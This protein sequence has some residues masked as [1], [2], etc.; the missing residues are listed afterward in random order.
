MADLPSLNIQQQN[1]DL[2]L[3]SRLGA[4]QTGQPA[5]TVYNL[6]PYTPPDTK[7]LYSYQ[8]SPWADLAGSIY[9]TAIMDTGQGLSNLIPTLANTVGG[10]KGFDWAN[11]W[12]SSVDSWMDNNK[13]KISDAGQKS[14][15][16][17]PSLNSFASTL[18][19]VLGFVGL[20][21]GT[22][23][24]GGAAGATSLV[25]RT[26]PSA[27]AV[28]LNMMPQMSKM[29]QDAGIPAD[30]A[31]RMSLLLS[32]VMGASSVVGFNA[33]MGTAGKTV[34]PKLIED[35]GLDAAEDAIKQV[36]SAPKITKEVMYDAVKIANRTFTDKLK[37]ALPKILEG[38]AIG[39]ADMGAQTY[40]TE[41]LKNLYDTTIA[42]SGAKT[43]KGMFGADVTSYDTF[44][45]AFENA[46]LGGIIG[47][48]MSSVHNF[49]QPL[50]RE[51][52]FSYIGNA[53]SDGKPE[54]ITQ[55]EDMAQKKIQAG[56][57]TPEDGAQFATT[58]KNLVD[59]NKII[60]TSIK[61]NTTRY[62]AFNIISDR[63]EIKDTLAKL[64]QDA[65]T[66]DPSLAQSDAAEMSIHQAKID[67]Y[68]DYLQKIGRDKSPIDEKE[69]YSK[70]SKLDGIQEDL[71]DKFEKNATEETPHEDVDTEEEPEPTIESFMPELGGEEAT[72]ETQA[73][74][75]VEANEQGEEPNLK[76]L[77]GQMEDIKSTILKFPVDGDPK[78]VRALKKQSS[79]I[80][81]K[82]KILEDEQKL[83]DKENAKT[84]PNNENTEVEP[85][86][87][88]TAE[89]KPTA[90]PKTEVPAVDEKQK[91]VTTKTQ[92]NEETKSVRE[93]GQSQGQEGGD[94]GEQP[95]RQENGRQGKE[96]ATVAETKG[97]VEETQLRKDTLGRMFPQDDGKAF[98]TS[99]GYD[100]PMHLMN[101]VNKELGKKLTTPD[102]VT[103]EDAKTVAKK[104]V[105]DAK[106]AAK[107]VKKVK[108][109]KQDAHAVQ[110]P[111]TEVVHGSEQVETKQEGSKLSGVGEGEQGSKTPK[112]SKPA[113]TKEVSKPDKTVEKQ[114]DNK[115][116]EKK[117]TTKKKVVEEEPEPKNKV[118]EEYEDEGKRKK[119]EEEPDIEELAKQQEKRGGNQKA[120]TTDIKKANIIRGKI[121]DHTTSNEA[122]KLVND[123][124]DRYE[125]EGAESLKASNV[126]NLEQNHADGLDGMGLLKLKAFVEDNII[127]VKKAKSQAGGEMMTASKSIGNTNGLIRD[128]YKNTTKR[129]GALQKDIAIKQLIHGLTNGFTITTDGGI[130][131][132]P[133]PYEAMEKGG[134]I[135]LYK[136]YFDAAIKK[137]TG[138]GIKMGDSK[139][140]M[141]NAIANDAFT[142]KAKGYGERKGI[143]TESQLDEAIKELKTK[144]QLKKNQRG[145]TPFDLISKDPK[146]YQALKN[147]LAK[148]Y[149]DFIVREPQEIADK[150]GVINGI[151][152]VE[153]LKRVV[154]WS[155][156]DGRLD[157]MPHEYM[158]HYIQDMVNDPL[159]QEGIKKY[160]SEEA[161]VQAMGE[162][163]TKDFMKHIDDGQKTW[164]GK[165]I[166]KVIEKLRSMFATT[167]VADKI[168]QGFRKGEPL[169]EPKSDGVIGYQKP[170]QSEID[171]VQ[172]DRRNWVNLTA[173]EDKALDAFTTRTL[174]GNTSKTMNI[175]KNIEKASVLSD[176][177]IQDKLTT[178][179]GTKEMVK[180]VGKFVMET[181]NDYDANA[182]IGGT[183]LNLIT[184][185]KINKL[186]DL[187]SVGGNPEQQVNFVEQLYKSF[188]YIAAHGEIPSD[189]PKN[190]L[191]N[192]LT[193][194]SAIEHNRTMKLNAVKY[195]VGSGQAV[196]DKTGKPIFNAKGKPVMEATRID[197]DKANAVGHGEINNVFTKIAKAGLVA[198]GSMKAI[199]ANP[200]AVG[201][202]TVIESISGGKDSF[203]TKL[204][205]EPQ[206]KGAR[207][208][209][210][211]KRDM[212]D[213][214]HEGMTEANAKGTTFM[215]NRTRKNTEKLSFTTRNGV[216]DITKGE[217]FSTYMHAED[218]RYTEGIIDQID[219]DGKIKEGS[220]FSLSVDGKE[221]KIHFTQDDYDKFKASFEKDKELMKA[222]SSARKITDFMHE[223]INE[224]QQILTGMPTQKLPNYWPTSV[225][226]P[227]MGSSPMVN[228]MEAY[229]G[230]KGRTGT[231]EPIRLGDG[232]EEL[233]R[234]MNDANTY[235]SKAIP[236][237]T[238]KSWIGNKENQNVLMGHG[239]EKIVRY[240]NN[241]ITNE[242][243]SRLLYGLNNANGERSWMQKSLNNLMIS[244]VGFNPWVLVKQL[245]AVTL[246]SSEFGGKQRYMGKAYA[247]VAKI[248]ANGTVRGFKINENHPLFQEIKQHAPYLINRI[249]TT[250]TGDLLQS[251]GADVM[252]FNHLKTGDFTATMKA[253]QRKST[254]MIKLADYGRIA[255]IW[256]ASKLWVNDNI[257]SLQESSKAWHK[258]V[259][260][261]A[262]QVEIN[263]QPTYDSVHRTGLQK[264]Q[265][266]LI[267]A[268]TLFG[269]QPAKNLDMLISSYINNFH[270]PSAENKAIM[271]RNYINVIA[272]NSIL[273]SAID[274]SKQAGKHTTKDNEEEMFWGL[275]KTNL[276]NLPG[277]NMLSE[278]MIS[279]LRRDK[280]H[281]FVK[282]VSAPW[283]DMANDGLNAM[284]LLAKGKFDKGIDK[285]IR[286]GM[287]LSGVPN[288]PYRFAQSMFTKSK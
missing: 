19:N 62:Q 4:Q 258:A 190:V 86:S 24:L 217:A 221:T 185:E 151:A 7:D 271:R 115:A 200:N 216:H 268:F 196:N 192:F 54:R 158:H 98:A 79:I 70:I 44:K 35:L 45:Q 188:N 10:D 177:D 183:D 238:L 100:H 51:S 157:T 233:N 252:N 210:D 22:S 285:T 245:P 146:T 219:K 111:S 205:Y 18:G 211:N 68:N 199:L 266:P 46:A 29:A 137:E 84:K 250:S 11:N 120:E 247:T 138:L 39:A 80:K 41:G 135:K 255:G 162:S 147:A 142:P 173:A 78:V 174:R 103:I 95:E 209:E 25:A 265:N 15:F 20:M 197:A 176:T 207:D 94:K 282:N 234:F 180:H 182:K 261:K 145:E 83:K 193:L 139:S 113:E 17:D 109:T 212:A 133:S 37:T 161:L 179:E 170:S 213:L 6:Q 130:H 106:A 36:A 69:L 288:Y 229:K 57:M 155:I 123:I 181:L 246:T 48:G 168:L 105:A 91:Q 126:R 33:I 220:G 159:V 172:N 104:K 21:A 178:S 90:E 73:V 149:P 87:E 110:K 276:N 107:E 254:S 224:T 9:N 167:D 274:M 3:A 85:K 56:K 93:D 154:E 136:D 150:D 189:I 237:H 16:T 92:D 208:F 23:G 140:D 42:P 225:G 72:P 43:G 60:P 116:V 169:P 156:T 223:K 264:N 281:P 88:P 8:Q 253:L 206:N 2:N 231:N 67:I 260:N 226:S 52:L 12:T 198:R 127:H 143:M 50:M 118:D 248:I 236:L 132:I 14:F 280:E 119:P 272:V 202:K 215:G 243:N 101:D 82:I 122:A 124:F 31:A 204:L 81:E 263:T 165:F 257:P 114:R 5:A 273:M 77:Q 75:Q 259:S 184:K 286:V 235:A 96:T 144:P 128:L 227:T 244:A 40:M 191:S 228:F 222:V 278:A 65:S 164:I 55:V 256:E 203:L 269:S 38:S 27:I 129:L 148:L 201:L 284:A 166:G 53:M 99:L 240:V 102:D 141:I 214:F 26:A 232:F 1:L 239:Q 34:A 134:I 242:E 279:R 283:E 71:D 187:M 160:G 275:V 121:L 49:N 66:A 89:T 58:M 76:A 152:H 267:R 74:K 108:Q 175:E 125:K 28:T 131:E 171:R 64:Q 218:P 230:I 163:Y 32:G 251:T 112:E 13:S 270:N 241:Y 153:A 47:A 97:K 30:H 59:A 277:V 63:N 287:T 186:R 61:D 249:G 194:Q 117:T 262:M 195:I